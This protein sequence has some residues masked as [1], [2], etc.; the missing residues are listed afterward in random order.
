MTIE[1][2]GP[3]AAMAVS[4]EAALQAL[5]RDDTSL[6]LSISIAID[7]LTA[8]A[9]QITG[10]AF[11]NRA[12][13]VTLDAFPDA[14]RLASPTFSVE[15]VKYLDS[16]GVEQTLHPD[17][18]YVDKVTKPGYIVPAAGK[19]WP[20]T[21][22]RVNAVTVDFTAGYGPTD[23][24]V[25]NEAKHYILAR[26]QLQFDPDLNVKQQYLVRLLDPLAVF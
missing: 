25:P 19:A 2:I 11:V 8:E 13:R 6:D 24:T 9:E 23:A 14:I 26:L 4:M 5:R 15:S 21:F 10:R 20:S 12:M 22:A 7:A 3:P 18:Y 17:D 1:K 16:A